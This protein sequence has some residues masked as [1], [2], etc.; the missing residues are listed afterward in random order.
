E[1]LTGD[2]SID[3]E[4]EV[5]EAAWSE[6]PV[7]SLE[8]QLFDEGEEGT[9]DT[10]AAIDAALA[11]PVLGAGLEPRA[12]EEMIGETTVVAPM[13]I[14]SGGDPPIDPALFKLP[15]A[16]PPLIV[17]DDTRALADLEREI[18]HGIGLPVD[19]SAPGRSARLHL[20]A[21]IAAQRAG[22]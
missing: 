15:E 8:E 5:D 7:A 1:P 14:E 12:E 17:A 13:P 18:E 3:L 11:E 19:E 21:G 4:G 2:L 20:Y 9:T 16:G 22:D 6:E 10:E